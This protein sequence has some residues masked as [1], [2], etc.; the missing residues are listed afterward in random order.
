MTLALFPS[1]VDA[2]CP[3]NTLRCYPHPFDAGFLQTTDPAASQCNGSVNYDLAAGYLHAAGSGGD[4]G[5]YGVVDAADDYW[6]TGLPAG[7]PLSF[8]VLLRSRGSASANYGCGP[9]SGFGHATVTLREGDSNSITVSANAD[10]CSP[11]YVVF[12]SLLRLSVQRNAGEVFALSFVLNTGGNKGGGSATAQLSFATLPQGAAVV[13]C[14][15][16]RQDFPVVARVVT[17]GA[18]KQ[19]YR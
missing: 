4:Q 16:F 3:L 19:V 12:D 17:W 9:F 1:Q 11:T 8:E 13:S 15:G 7:T 14:Q 2:V 18:L 5:G 6:I 10:G